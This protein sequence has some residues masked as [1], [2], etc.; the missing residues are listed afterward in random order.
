[1]DSDDQRTVLLH[2]HRL[3]KCCSSSSTQEGSWLG[4]SLSRDVLHMVRYVPQPEGPAT[5]RSNPSEFEEW[6]AEVVGR[7][8]S[9]KENRSS[10]PSREQQEPKS[11]RVVH[12]ELIPAQL[13]KL[14]DTCTLLLDRTP[15]TQRTRF[16]FAQDENWISYNNPDHS[17]EW[18]DFDQDLEFVAKQSTHGKKDVSFDQKEQFTGRS[19]EKVKLSTPLSSAS[20]WIRWRAEFS[21]AAYGKAKS[22]S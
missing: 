3:G 15:N 14:V 19:S 13:K 20:N 11:P 6:C 18:C 22:C 8:R 16:I 21:P 7:D 2:L 4:S 9:F 5:I 1:M 17:L 12:R 10:C